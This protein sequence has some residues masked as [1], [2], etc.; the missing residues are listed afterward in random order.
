[1]PKT[2]D[3]QIKIENKIPLTGFMDATKTKNSK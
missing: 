3:D 2:T 1:M